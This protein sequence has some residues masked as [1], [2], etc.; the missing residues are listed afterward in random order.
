MNGKFSIPQ[1]EEVIRKGIAKQ[2]KMTGKPKKVIVVGAGVAGL[3][4]ASE[5]LAAGHDLLILEAQQRVGGRIYTLR[6]PFAQGLYGEAD[7]K[8]VV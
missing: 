3:V 5:L 2:F 4:A 8:S 6:Q 1:Y 7:R